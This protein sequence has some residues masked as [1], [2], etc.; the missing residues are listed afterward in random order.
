MRVLQG[1]K[2]Q[3]GESEKV[4]ESLRPICWKGPKSWHWRLDEKKKQGRCDIASAS[5]V[6]G[7]PVK[8]HFPFGERCQVGNKSLTGEIQ[9][10]I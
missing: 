1:V 6:L 3:S 10:L 2:L 7:A 4:D 5:H 8:V 9:K